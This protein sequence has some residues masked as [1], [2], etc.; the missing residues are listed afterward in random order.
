MYNYFKDKNLIKL[1]KLL[2]ETNLYEDFIKNV[3]LDTDKYK[4]WVKIAKEIQKAEKTEAV[5]RN[6]K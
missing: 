5:E 6:E 1:Y 4:N 2:K 3:I